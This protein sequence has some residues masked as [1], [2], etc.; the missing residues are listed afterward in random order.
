MT[1]IQDALFDHSGLKLP[2]GGRPGRYEVFKVL[3]NGTS[4]ILQETF[5]VKGNFTEA[6]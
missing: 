6:W 2:A 5:L 3:I 4:N 1:L